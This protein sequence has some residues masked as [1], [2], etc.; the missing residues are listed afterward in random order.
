[1][2]LKTFLSHHGIWI[3]ISIFAIWF[4]TFSF[5]RHLKANSF[6]FDLGYY[7]QLIWQLAHG[8]PLFSTLLENHPWLDHFSPSIFL[9]SPVYLFL[10]STLVIL[11][12]QSILIPLGAYPLYKIAVKKLKNNLV[13][14][15][16]SF[17]YLLFWGLHNAIS[18]DFHPL[19]LG[20]PLLAF[21]VYF[22][23]QKQHRLFYISMLLFAGLQEN[24]LIFLAF[25]GVFLALHYKDY[26]RGIVLSLLSGL[27][28][29][30]LIFFVIPHYFGASYYYLPDSGPGG[31]SVSSLLA[32][33][34]TPS[35]K[36]EVLLF[37]F[38]PTA[39]LSFLSPF[40]FILF[41]EEFAGRFLLDNPNWWG[42]GYHYNAILATLTVLSTIEGLKKIPKRFYT[43]ISIYFFI[44]SIA[45]FLYIQPDTIQIFKPSYWN[46]TYG[47]TVRNV[48]SHIPN[49]ASVAAGNNIG[50]QI[51]GRNE[52]YFITN[53]LDTESVSRTDG[54]L[55]HNKKPDYLVADLSNTSNWNNFVYGYDRDVVRKLF[56]DKVSQGE[57]E[58]VLVQEEIYLLKRIKK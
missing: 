2:R 27:T 44:V 52:I 26:K 20:A 1:M 53:C 42:L 58:K 34:V 28:F 11:L 39:F 57:Y 19:A 29:V 46:L 23:E 22:Y 13:A 14:L 40:H 32:K 3:L 37:T 4:T 7:D 45:C 8:K 38:L 30:S 6:L 16:L 41:F 48:V 33:F 36:L 5:V 56:S 51:A 49:D 54:K 50:A 9:L 17:V 24:Y 15:S 21:I 18:F 43:F 12:T 35:V 10:P 47:N 55:C 31:F 25:F